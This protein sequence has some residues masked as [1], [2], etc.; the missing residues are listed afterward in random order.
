MLAQAF[1]VH[2]R[3]V[4]TPDFQNSHLA[5]FDK[6]INTMKALSKLKEITQNS[7]KNPQN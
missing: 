4:V 7:R 5:I 3:I 2:P 6:N 1:F